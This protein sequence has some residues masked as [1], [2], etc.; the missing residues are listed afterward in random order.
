MRAPRQVALSANGH[1]V[2]WQE[3]TGPIRVGDVTTGKVRL[4]RV[5]DGNVVRNLM[6]SPD[7]KSV[8]TDDAL[9]WLTGAKAGTAEKLDGVDCAAF[10]ADGRYLALTFWNRWDAVEVRDLRS[11]MS[12]R[13]RTTSPPSQMAL[14]ADGQTLAAAIWGKV[15]LS[16]VAPKGESDVVVA[17]GAD[18]FVL[19]PDGT[20]LAVSTTDGEVILRDLPT[21][22]T[23]ARRRWEGRYNLRLLFSPTGRWLATLDTAGAV[24]LFDGLTGAVAGE[25]R[26]P[27]GDF[28]AVGIDDASHRLLAVTSTGE[29]LAWP[30]PP[31]ATIHHDRLSTAELDRLWKQLG[32]ETAGVAMR[33]LLRHPGQLLPLAGA[34]LRLTRPDLATRLT[35]DFAL[36]DLNDDDWVV[37]RA[38]S[39]KLDE[40]GTQ[41]EAALVRARGK[42][43]VEASLR[44]EVLLQGIEARRPPAERRRALRAVWLLERVGT[45]E[46]C[47][48]LRALAGPGRPLLM[49][50]RAA[51]SLRRLAARG[52]HPPG[53][54]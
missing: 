9:G 35:I 49:Q 46:A 51:E 12:V 36:A 30:L 8:V 16:R 25:Y 26:R 43:P 48:A 32:E 45:P 1:V 37:R 19:S 2:C 13:L 14:S 41:A 20:T 39:R 15:W 40:L 54:P 10:S 47:A 7:G 34:R 53:R 21:G 33:A 11:G 50:E 44:V 3:E 23:L 31:R 17:E 42:G 24:R 27:C 28:E 4:I 29:V 6:P 22:M 18:L 5:S 52:V 38:A